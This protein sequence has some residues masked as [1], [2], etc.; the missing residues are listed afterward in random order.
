MSLLT[1]VLRNGEIRV[2]AGADGKRSIDCAGVGQTRR[3]WLG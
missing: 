2:T 1:D 3:R